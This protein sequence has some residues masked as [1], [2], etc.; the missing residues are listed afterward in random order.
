MAVLS[1]DEQKLW[2]YCVAQ[3]RGPHTVGSPLPLPLTAM[4]VSPTPPPIM[5]EALP[6]IA[7]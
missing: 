3:S 5:D 4:R 2:A 1:Q 6:T 7:G